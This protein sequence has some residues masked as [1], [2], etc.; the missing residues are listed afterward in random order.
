[1][2]SLEHIRNMNDLAALKGARVKL[3]GLTLVNA[4]TGEVASSR[5]FADVN[6]ARE[7]CA[8]YGAIFAGVSKRSKLS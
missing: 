7:Y 2:H 8:K 6:M 5:S 3:V 1:M 4:K